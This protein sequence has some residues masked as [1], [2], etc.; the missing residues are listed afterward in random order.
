MHTFSWTLSI[1]IPAF[2]YITCVW[3][4]N[5]TKGLRTA[6]GVGMGVGKN[7]CSRAIYY[8]KRR[9]FRRYPGMEKRKGKG[10]GGC[11]GGEGKEMGRTS[12]I[13]GI[14]ML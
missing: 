11:V 7:S 12:E 2:N 4:E 1:I 10:K 6:A 14:P 9:S 8:T 5:E 13:R 3:T